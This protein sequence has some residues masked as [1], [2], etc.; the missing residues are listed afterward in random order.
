[1]RRTEAKELDI[2]SSQK[3]FFGTI[4]DSELLSDGSIIGLS[5]INVFDTMSHEIILYTLYYIRNTHTN[6][7]VYSLP[8]IPTH[9]ILYTLCET[10]LQLAFLLRLLVLTQ[11]I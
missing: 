10:Y 9:C 4:L 6:T 11:N 5:A 8:I 3:R 1:M 7:L 2:S